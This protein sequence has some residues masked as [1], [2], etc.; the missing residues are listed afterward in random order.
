MNCYYCHNEIFKILNDECKEFYNLT[1][2]MC[3]DCNIEYLF[4]SGGK[5]VLTNFYIK[6]NDILYA[7]IKDEAGVKLVK[8]NTNQVNNN[9]AIFHSST[10]LESKNLE[11]NP[12][13]ILEKTSLYLAFL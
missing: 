7:W 1:R 10:L 4:S 11:I 8:I 2:F 6:F 12:S 9:S 3:H 13:N 5:L